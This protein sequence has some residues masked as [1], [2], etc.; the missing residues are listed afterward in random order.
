MMST[1]GRLGSGTFMYTELCGCA[2]H[3]TC[4]T[5]ITLSWVPVAHACNP[6]YSGG[7]D[8]EDHGSKSAGQT[9]CK[10]LSQNYP[11]QN[12][13]GRVAQVVECLP[14]KKREALSS[15]QRTAKK[16]KKKLGLDV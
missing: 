15:N 12:R 13:A 1:L 8:Q 3:T 4:I 14:G 11:T 5:L 2:C 6:S 7:R 9:V 16:K 10:T